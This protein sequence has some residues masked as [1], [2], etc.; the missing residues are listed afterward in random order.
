MR[1]KIFNQ[2]DFSTLLFDTLFGLVLFYSFDSL[3]DIKSPLNFIFYLFSTIIV[4]HWWLMFKSAD[5]IYAEEVAD[6]AADLVIGILEVIFLDYVVII[7][8]GATFTNAIYYLF[9]LFILDLGWAFIWRFVGVWRTTNTERIGFMQGRLNKNIYIDIFMILGLSCL[10]ATQNL[11]S[12]LL[13]SIVYM[14]LYCL[15]MAFTFI[16]KVVDIDIF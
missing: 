6:S 12:P 1:L 10:I 11:F 7:S 9:A 14:A 2:L 5:D 8:R 13:F 16:Y 15:Y 4:V 3:L